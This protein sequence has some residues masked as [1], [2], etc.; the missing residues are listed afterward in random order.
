MVDLNLASRR[1]QRNLPKV[2]YREDSDSDTGADD[3]FNSVA[4]N[5]SQPTTPLSP[6]NPNFLLQPSPPPTTQV[7]RDV[8]SNLRV[9]EVVQN[10]TPVWPP[11][12]STEEV[13]EGNIIEVAE[14]LKLSEG[15]NS[16]EP[17][18]VQEVR[19]VNYDQQNEEDDAGAIQNARDVK[20]PFNKNDI[21]L[22]FSLIESKMQFAGIKNN[23]QRGRS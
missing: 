2:D 8:A 22:W 4:S 17:A 7:L 12:E 20:F 11:L 19:M 9:V 10:I 16:T 21:Q 1:P 15:N 18:P 23:G 13:V 6:S 5:L 14:N 3:T